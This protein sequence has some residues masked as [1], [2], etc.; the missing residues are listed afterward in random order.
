MDCWLCWL[1]PTCRVFSEVIDSHFPEGFEDKKP[2]WS[3]TG[4]R[5]G[6][7][8][9]SNQT[10]FGGRRYPDFSA[11]DEVNSHSKK[12]TGSQSAHALIAFTSQLP[13]QEL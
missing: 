4:T 2:A 3:F 6:S 8:A 1:E 9:T 11:T 12:A 5:T 7:L 13:S 10:A